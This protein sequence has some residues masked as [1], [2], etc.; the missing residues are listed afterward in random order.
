MWLPGTALCFQ[1]L[2]AILTIPITL[3]VVVCV[4][5]MLYYGFA[6]FLLA[7]DLVSH[8]G[9]QLDSNEPDALCLLL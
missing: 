8:T 1:S 6:I 2:L 7:T 9:S 4:I 3:Y 5:T